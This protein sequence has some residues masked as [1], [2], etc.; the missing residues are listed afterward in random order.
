LLDGS[1]IIRGEYLGWAAG[2]ETAREVEEELR[3]WLPLGV[4]LP[5]APQPQR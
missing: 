3:R 5:P 1:N 4:S 2:G